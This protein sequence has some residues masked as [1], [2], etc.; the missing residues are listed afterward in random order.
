ME[1]PTGESPET[2]YFW[3]MPENVGWAWAHLTDHT[4][5]RG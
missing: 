1:D 3:G 5:L 4:T 2:Q